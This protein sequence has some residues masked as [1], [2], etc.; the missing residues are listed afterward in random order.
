MDEMATMLQ[1]IR[2]TDRAEETS[3]LTTRSIIRQAVSSMLTKANSLSQ[4]ALSLLGCVLAIL[5]CDQGTAGV[6]RAQAA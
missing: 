2:E 6:M 3:N 1:R 4:M 5:S